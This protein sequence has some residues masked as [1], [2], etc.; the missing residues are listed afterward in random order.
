[1]IYSTHPLHPRAAAMLAPVGGVRVASAHDAATLAR[2]GHEAEIV[3]VRVPIPAAL[4]DDPPNLRAAI[5]HGAG[6]DMVPMEAATRAGVLVA[7]TPGVNARTVAEHVMLMAL[8]LRRRM[9]P[10]DRALRGSGW[11]AGR[12]ATDVAHELSGATLGIIGMGDIGHAVAAI[13]TGGFGLKVI[14][15]TRTPARIRSEVEPVGLDALMARADIVV[16]ACPLTDATRCL[17]G[18]AALAR[19]KP[20]AYLV[21]VARGAIVDDAALIA[22]LAAG[23]IA[24]AALDV[25]AEQPLPPDHPYMSLP[26][27]IVTPHVAGVTDESLMRMATGAAAEALRVLAGALPVNLRN[28]EA[29][30][31]YRTRFP[32]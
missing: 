32:G 25:F 9:V 16:I 12:A 17:I 15:H 19:M 31:R 14:A 29:V 21:N 27:V 26:N 28:P 30:A 7:N 3:I 10:I 1:M 4:F 24:G 2:E 11:A 8:A 20:G 23:R 18:A 13:A 6:L 22:A 5:R